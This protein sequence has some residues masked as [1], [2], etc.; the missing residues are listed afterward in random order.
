MVF[1]REV[2]ITQ[3][4]STRLITL[5]LVFKPLDKDHFHRLRLFKQVILSAFSAS[6]QSP[7]PT[8]YS[9]LELLAVV[10]F[11]AILAAGNQR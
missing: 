6:L 11:I 5:D 10:V 2:A 8:S 3:L 4:V 1:V 7:D 9:F